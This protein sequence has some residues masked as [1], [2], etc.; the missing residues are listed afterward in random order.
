[1]PM[2]ANE[3]GKILRI[4]TKYDL[5]GATA[6]QLDIEDPDGNASLINAGFTVGAVDVTDNESNEV[7]TAYQY[8]EY[9]TDGT[10]F[11]Q[12]GDH[13]SKL[14]GDFGPGKTLKSVY[15]NIYVH[16]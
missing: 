8:V 15:K 2:I 14:T 3:K 4:N 9:T 13:P 11:V 6:F 12:E 7:L 16:A 10:E 1:M 5:T